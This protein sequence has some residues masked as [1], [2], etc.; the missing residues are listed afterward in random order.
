LE[1]PCEIQGK[2]R[3]VMN[4]LSCWVKILPDSSCPMA[5]ACVKDFLMLLMGFSHRLKLLEM[6]Q[7]KEMRY[8]FEGH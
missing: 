7:N 8:T 4:V 3:T 5:A 2:P 6:H 1:T